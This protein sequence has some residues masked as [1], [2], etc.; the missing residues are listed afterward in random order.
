MDGISR[1]EHDEFCKRME[2]EHKRISH[3]LSD[4]EESVRQIGALTASV[5]KLALSVES[6]AKT[7]TRQGE[8]LEELEGRD[9]E[10]W[11]TITSYLLTAIAGALV[12]YMLTKIGMA[13]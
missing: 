2:D 6:M 4:L 11:R 12:T 9:G 7:Q 13:M 10:K 8:R 3:R 1:E 5:E